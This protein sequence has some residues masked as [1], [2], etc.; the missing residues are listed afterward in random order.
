MNSRII[1]IVYC[2]SYRGFTI[3]EIVQWQLLESQFQFYSIRYLRIEAVDK[4]WKQM[5]EF[6]RENRSFAG[7][8]SF[9]NKKNNATKLWM[10][11]YRMNKDI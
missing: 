10:T 9:L 8:E 1:G 11:A 3:M 4:M 6:I 7:T 5:I 2:V